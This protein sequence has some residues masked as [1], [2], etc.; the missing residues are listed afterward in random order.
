MGTPPPGYDEE[1]VT[2]TVHWHGFASLSAAEE[3]ES[4]D[5]LEF[6]LLGNQWR[7]QIYP[8][9]DEDAAEG[10]VSTFLWNR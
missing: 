1:W 7:M 3:G 6:M 8:G 9:G 4:V 10:R 5:S 2:H